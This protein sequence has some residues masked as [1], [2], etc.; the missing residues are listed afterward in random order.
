MQEIKAVAAI[1]N[2]RN[3]QAQS[4]QSFHS[5]IRTSDLH[6]HH[7]AEGKS[8]KKHGQMEFMVQPIERRAD[9]LQFSTAMVVL[10]V[11]QSRTAKIEAQHR[12]AKM[13]SA[14][15]WRETQ[16]CYAASRHKPDA[17]GTPVPAYFAS[18]EPSFNKASSRPAGPSRNRDR[19][20]FGAGFI[21]SLSIA[22]QR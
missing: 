10:S 7:R 11:T 22:R 16:L 19:I 5:C 18:L 20:A 3:W 15:S 1:I 8:R 9:I 2:R 13:C 12:K 17:D 14:L 6:S 21:R 4:N